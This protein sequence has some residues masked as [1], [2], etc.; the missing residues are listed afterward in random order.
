MARYHLKRL[1]LLAAAVLCIAPSAC[2]INLIES[3]E[4]GQTSGS[5]Y[6][7]GG[8]PANGGGGGAEE[9]TGVGGS[10]NCT[11]GV[12]FG[13]GGAGGA[14]YGSVTGVGGAG[15]ASYGTSAVSV[16]VGGAG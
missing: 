13:V 14:S 3:T 1:S 6:A 11:S 4:K 2:T 7:V 5:G 16:G 8:G 12:G 15:G 9:T 10:P